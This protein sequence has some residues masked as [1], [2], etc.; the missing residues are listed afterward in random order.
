MPVL[1]A[2]EVE[3]VRVGITVSQVDEFVLHQMREVGV[4]ADVPHAASCHG[5][6][7]GLTPFFHPAVVEIK[8]VVALIEFQMSA[9]RL[10]VEADEARV[11]PH[12]GEEGLQFLVFVFGVVVGSRSH[13]GPFIS[14]GKP[15][16]PPPFCG[17]DVRGHACGRGWPRDGSPHGL[18]QF[19]GFVFSLQS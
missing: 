1:V 9:V 15:G 12:G 19:S 6:A 10:W 18:S 13:F 2:D 7:D 4:G 16:V 14:G 3:D 11:L 8:T 5:S 17:R